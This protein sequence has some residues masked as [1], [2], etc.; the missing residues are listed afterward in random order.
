MSAL[1]TA[2]ITVEGT[3]DHTIGSAGIIFIKGNGVRL[4]SKAAESCAFMNGR[5][6][7][8]FGTDSDLGVE[9]TPETQYRCRYYVVVCGI[10]FVSNTLTFTTTKG[11]PRIVI[12]TPEITMSAGETAILAPRLLY[13][14]DEI[15]WRSSNS[16]VAYVLDN[17]I[18]AVGPGAAKLTAR[19]A[20]DA[21]VQAE[22][23]VTVN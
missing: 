10:T 1:L 22:C 7:L 11:I 9:L 13:C 19:L 17:E 20:S 8:S 2:E 23:Y 21:N 12:D 4:A 16:S 5:C 3:A 18:V 14:V 6:T 15:V